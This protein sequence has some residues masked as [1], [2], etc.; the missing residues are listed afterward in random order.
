MCE[1]FFKN[2]NTLSRISMVKGVASLASAVSY[3]SIMLDSRVKTVRHCVVK[4]LTNTSHVISNSCQGQP[5]SVCTSST[6]NFLGKWTHHQE[7]RVSCLSDNSIQFN[8]IM[9]H[10]HYNT[11][12]WLE[13]KELVLILNVFVYI[14]W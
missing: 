9:D 10:S 11:S 5:N 2:V 8:L 12:A 13:P 1:F 7:R 4:R 3:P 6:V 14:E